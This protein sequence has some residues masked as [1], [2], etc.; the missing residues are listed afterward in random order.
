[1]AAGAARQRLARLVDDIHIMARYG[2]AYRPVAHGHEVH[3]TAPDFTPDVAQ[4]LRQKGAQVHGVPL[5]RAG[6]SLTGDIRYLRRIRRLVREVEADL[7]VSYTI[8]PNIWA[9]F[10]ARSCGVRSASL[11]TGLGYAF[12]DGKGVKRRVISAASK[13][14]CGLA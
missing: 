7:V 5:S 2:T 14:L 1:M 3:V 9:S 8:K 6:L 12:I 4:V 10:A 13:L 11:V